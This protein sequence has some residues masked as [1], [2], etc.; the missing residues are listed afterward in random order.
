MLGRER[1]VGT[2]EAH[3]TVGSHVTS[4]HGFGQ[5]GVGA[6]LALDLLDTVVHF[7][8]VFVMLSVQSGER[9]SL[10]FTHESVPTASG[11]VLV[12]L[13]L[14]PACFSTSWTRSKDVQW[15]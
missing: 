12:D 14:G 13:Q 10:N 3:D 15:L 4:Q 9:A 6:L 5:T 1:A 11:S 8:V 2:S 7:H